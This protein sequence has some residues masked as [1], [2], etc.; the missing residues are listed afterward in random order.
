MTV[1]S[2]NKAPLPDVRVL[3][4]AIEIFLTHAY[5][6]GAPA[7]AERFMPPVDADPAEWL[8]GDLVE[9]TDP[10]A[11]LGRVRSFA[12]R[13]GNSLYPHMKLRLS[14]VGDRDLYVLTVDSHDAFLQAPPETQDHAELESLKRHNAAVVSA[15]AGAMDAAGLPTERNFLRERIRH[16][17][18][19]KG[20]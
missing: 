7:A 9:R 5:P 18:R 6:Q 11:P 4:E 10:D 19:G 12:L 3:R 13:I 16:A 15:V 14:R 1:S 17:K 8:M 20:G 2:D